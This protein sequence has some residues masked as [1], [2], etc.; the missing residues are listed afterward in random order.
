[1]ENVHGIIRRSTSRIGPP[2]DKT[3]ITDAAHIKPIF[4]EIIFAPAFTGQLA[5]A[6]N[7]IR[8]HYAVLRGI[9]LRRMRPKNCDRAWPENLGYFKFDSKIEYMQQTGHV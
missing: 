4:G 1:M 8:I 3:G 7:R 6:I 5:E 9:V 2:A